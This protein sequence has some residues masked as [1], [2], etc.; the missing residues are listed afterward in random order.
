MDLPSRSELGFR[1]YL[2]GTTALTGILML[3]GVYTAAAGAGLTCAQRWPLCDGAVF[4]LFPADWMS[5]IE[6]F[7]RLVAMVAGFVILGAT[8]HAWRAGRSRRVRGALTV[9]TVLLPAQ[10][11]L[12]ALT[13]TR[14]EWVILTAH[15]STATLIYAGVALATGWSFADR[16]APGAARR[17]TLAAAGLL[18]AFLVLSPRLLFVY[19]ETA[20]VALYTVGL[21]ALAALCWATV[22]TRAAGGSSRSALATGLAAVVLGGLL[23][24]GRQVFGTSAQLAMVGGSLLA[25]YL[26]F[27]AAHWG[28]LPLAGRA[29][30]VPGTERG[31]RSDD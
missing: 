12:G 27:G 22:W 15:F 19:G 28:E 3:L 4:G 29:R 20:Q 16:V 23:V 5:F 17:A 8:A 7:H 6:W 14:Y 25:F 26:A 13:V 21:A 9:A 1:H 24:L 18:P 2:A 10:I 30:G 31:S 11:I